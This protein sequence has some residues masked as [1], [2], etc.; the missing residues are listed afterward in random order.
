MD[1]RFFCFYPLQGGDDNYRQLLYDDLVRT[2]I[3]LAQ[4]EGKYDSL[5]DPENS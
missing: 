2:M 1:Q 3:M 4:E 5:Y